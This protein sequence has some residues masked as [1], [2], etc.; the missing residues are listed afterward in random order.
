LLSIC[1]PI[2]QYKVYS[3]I[4][5]L[6]EQ[7]KLTSHPYEIICIDDNSDLFYKKENTKIEEFKNVSYTELQN[8]VGRSKI[9][10]LFI[11]KAKFNSLLFLDCDCSIPNK[12]F[13]QK[14]YDNI[15]YDLTYGGRKH[16][17]SKPANKSVVLRWKYGKERE[18]LSFK[19][20]L[21]SPFISF[22]SNNF[23]IQ[24]QI[25][26]LVSFDESITK[27]GHEDTLFALQLKKEN[28]Y[29]KHIDN[30]VIHE[31]LE[32]NS[33]FIDKTKIAVDNLNDLI[34]NNKLNPDEIKLFKI[35][36]TLERTK[37]IYLMKLFSSFFIKLSSNKLL[38]K[39]PKIFWLDIYK[40]FYLIQIRHNV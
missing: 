39:N 20:R 22:R 7:C 17:D 36:Q 19:E 10:N 35:F 9:R 12:G 14:Y 23:L 33:E 16:Y 32:S 4:K 1:I 15:G 18:D 3:L 31:G 26:S 8:N 28:I 29:I 40:L 27:Y 2:Y 21:Q 30:I 13:I 34:K 6:N 25:L 38:K 37:I 5:E 24:K 11:E